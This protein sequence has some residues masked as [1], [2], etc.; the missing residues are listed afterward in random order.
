MQDNVF[1][2]ICNLQARHQPDVEFCLIFQFQA[3]NTYLATRCTQIL[4]THTYV[5]AA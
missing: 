3:C 5:Q 4:H 2:T 1:D